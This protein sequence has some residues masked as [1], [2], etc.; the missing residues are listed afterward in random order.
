MGPFIYAR[1]VSWSVN[2]LPGC[3]GLVEGCRAPPRQR[4]AAGVG[5]RA[6]WS[7]GGS[8]PMGLF[9]YN[10][11]LSSVVRLPCFLLLVLLLV[12]F[13]TVVRKVLIMSEVDL[14]MLISLVQEHPVLWDKT[15][16]DYKD[17]IKTTNA[18]IEVFKHLN[19][20]FEE[21]EDNKRNE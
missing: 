2:H 15:V 14:E 10:R 16:E 12:L 13:G 21:M 6:G 7:S 11:Q 19:G 4:P 17:R 20:G 9:T 8:G 1:L 3:R 5:Q 18:W